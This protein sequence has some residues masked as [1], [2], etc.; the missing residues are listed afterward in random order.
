MFLICSWPLQLLNLL[1]LIEKGDARWSNV[2][3]LWPLFLIY[4]ILGLIEKER[5]FAVVP[6][7]NYRPINGHQLYRLFNIHGKIPIVFS[8]GNF[9]D[10]SK[11]LPY[12]V[13]FGI[14]HRNVNAVAHAWT[15]A[16]STSCT[17]STAEHSRESLSKF[18]ELHVCLVLWRWYFNKVRQKL[19]SMKVSLNRQEIPQVKDNWNFYHETRR[20]YRRCHVICGQ[21]FLW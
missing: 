21:R 2:D 15:P 14:A 4:S 13:T 5:N 6:Y 19:L 3:D 8:S 18:S 1:R 9:V 11:K 16:A 7:R 17:Y 10:N 20:E 12:L